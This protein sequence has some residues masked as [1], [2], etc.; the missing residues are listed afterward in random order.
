V[1]GVL[2]GLT[3]TAEQPSVRRM[4]SFAL[5]ELAPDRPEAARALLA[6][7]R[8]DDEAV[9]RAAVTALAG[10]LDPPAEVAE[11]LDELRRGRDAVLARLAG[12]A[13]GALEETE[14]P[15]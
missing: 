7:T 8:D 9:R 11:R 6:A 13:L 1:L 4:A 2:L 15:R 12:R 10:L 5:R 14:A 3:R